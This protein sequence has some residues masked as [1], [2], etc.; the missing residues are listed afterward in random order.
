MP[1]RGEEAQ[2]RL[3]GCR[4]ELRIL[5]AQ[6]DALRRVATLVARG[7]D[8]GEV[9]STVAEEMARCL[10]VDVAEVFGYESDSAARMLASYAE[11]GEPHLPAGYEIAL[12]GKSV[13]ATV[14][15][16]GRPA[17]ID[18]YDDITGSL[19]ARLR[20]IG[21]RC[22]VG[23][24]ILVN[25]RVWGLA[26]VG[27]SRL[28]PLPPDTE[29]R[30]AE[31]ADLVAIAIANAATRTELIASRARIV[32]AGDE[33]RRRLERDLHD[34]AQQRLVALALR[35]R[36]AEQSLP[37]DLADARQQMS[38]ILA[39]LTGVSEDLHE[40]SRGIHP[41]ILSR[42][43][44]G[45]ALKTLARRSTVPVALDVA[46]E[47]QVPESAEVAAYY[48]LAE[49]LTNAAKHAQASEVAVRVDTWE[50]HLN[51]VI[52][53]NGVGGANSQ[54]GSGLIGLQDRVE[55]LGGRMRITSPPH[56]GTSMHVRIPLDVSDERVAASSAGPSPA[57]VRRPVSRK[58][59]LVDLVKVGVGQR[60]LRAELRVEVGAGGERFPV[61]DLVRAPVGDVAIGGEGVGSEE[62]E[63]GGFG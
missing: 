36:N 43:G 46:I 44:L 61:C 57:T 23:A 56:H 10:D 2:V 6:H 11:P 40:I 52:T 15:R 39:G 48:V 54:K 9:L 18:D 47:R 4:D 55:A 22:R 63:C 51:L 25:E 34:G 7:A 60:I 33:A 19:A 59:D 20:E 26:I 30:V 1:P 14:L 17:R 27:S 31:F 35:L 45:P 37:P 62:Q 53:D 16:T 12:E 3:E 24:P 50:G 5:V 21:V 42:G 38:E 28:G 49:S 58:P 13:A 32:T 29:A 41:A 8:P